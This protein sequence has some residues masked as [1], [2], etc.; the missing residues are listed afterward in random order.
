MIRKLFAASLTLNA[1]FRRGPGKLW[2]A[3]KGIR[4]VDA[5]IPPGGVDR[6][7]LVRGAFV[8]GVSV[9]TNFSEL[10]Y[11]FMILKYIFSKTPFLVG[12]FFGSG[13]CFLTG[14]GVYL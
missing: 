8:D 12:D 14:M 4:P 7:G 10:Y 2:G 11:L 5:A 6:C 3:V 1:L 9:S 13:S